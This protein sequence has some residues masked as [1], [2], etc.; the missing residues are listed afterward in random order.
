[1][2]YHPSYKMFR[3]TYVVFEQT[4]WVSGDV[5]YQRKV[6]LVLVEIRSAAVVTFWKPR[7][8]L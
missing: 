2:N 3:A 7:Q 8:K 4:V 6:P 1:M 5:V